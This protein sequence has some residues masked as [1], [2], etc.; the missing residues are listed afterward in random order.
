MRVEPAYLHKESLQKT[1]Q[2]VIWKEK[3]TY[4]F[5]GGHIEHKIDIKEDNWSVEQSVILSD[6]GEVIGYFAASVSRV[7]KQVYNLTIAS[8]SEKENILVTVY[9][10]IKDLLTRF[11]KVC[12]AVNIGNPAEKVYDLACKR[13]GGRIV[14]IYKNQ[15]MAANGQMCDEKLYEIMSADYRSKNK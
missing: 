1:Y 7:K 14:G 5:C 4:Y 13:L 11:D 8:F 3:Y 10:L 2:S 15:N 6:S 12:F 9:L